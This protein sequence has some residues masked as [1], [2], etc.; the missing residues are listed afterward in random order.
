MDPLLKTQVAQQSFEECDKFNFSPIRIFWTKLYTDLKQTY[1]CYYC[2]GQCN[3]ALGYICIFINFFRSV[4]GLCIGC[5]L[6]ISSDLPLVQYSSMWHFLFFFFFGSVRL[7]K[8]FL[9]ILHKFCSS[10]L[11]HFSSSACANVQKKKPSKT[12]GSQSYSHTLFQF[13]NQSW[14]SP[15]L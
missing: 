9:F 6:N 1:L 2:C 15:S 13:P 5:Y 14:I 11:F 3:M 12:P 4:V 8:V 10:S 7:A